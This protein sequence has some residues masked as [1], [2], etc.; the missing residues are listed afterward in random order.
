M[1][2]GGGPCD[3]CSDPP[4][5][6]PQHR[7]GL[8][9]GGPDRRRP[10]GR[11]GGRSRRGGAD[12]RARSAQR[13]DRRA[14]G[15]PAPRPLGGGG[16]RGVHHVRRR[17]PLPEPPPGRRPPCRRGEQPAARPR[18]S[19]GHAG[20]PRRDGRRRR[21][22]HRP[23]AHP[24]RLRR[25]PRPAGPAGPLRRVPPDARRARPR[26]RPRPP[27][28]G[29]RQRRARWR[30]GRCGIPRHAVAAH[31]SHDG[32]RPERDRPHGDPRRGGSDHP[33]RRRARQLQ[34]H[35]G[36][37]LHLPCPHRGGPAFR[38]GGGARRPTRADPAGR[39][40]RP[41]HAAPLPSHRGG[42]RVLR[43]PPGG[44]VRAG[45][46]DVSPGDPR[47][48]AACG[49]HRP[50]RHRPRL[51]RSRRPPARARGPA[52]GR[53]RSPPGGPRRPHDRDPPARPPGGRPAP[54]DPR[55]GRLR[56]LH[57]PAHRRPRAGRRA[58][59]P[60]GR[61]LP[62]P[63]VHARAEPRRAVRGGLRPPGPRRRRP[64]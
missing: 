12:P 38:G 51:P 7:R 10:R 57:R 61:R 58:A 31:R 6:L 22:P 11:G 25:E 9:R 13:R 28:P 23:R 1:T 59:G 24:H 16:R 20:Q 40:R 63:G 39:C 48:P 55:P 45:G 21:A 44:P 52:R 32:D 43:L 41:G 33:R 27:L 5:A 2:P 47:P 26:R 46:G 37:R 15:L 35:R 50:G 62:P 3:P 30:S 4:R 14:A 19:V 49:A 29:G 60:A 8:L 17:R 36:R 64:T 54:G 34:Q 53:D 18:G 42:P 56:P